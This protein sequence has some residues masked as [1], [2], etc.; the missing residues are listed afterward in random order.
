[1]IAHWNHAFHKY[2]KLLCVA[3]LAVVQKK[4]AYLKNRLEAE[5]TQDWL[6]LDIIDANIFSLFA[7]A[8]LAKVNYLSNHL[9]MVILLF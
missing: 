3:L 1:M 9:R 5:L 4:Q 2:Q 6:G 7:L 8:E